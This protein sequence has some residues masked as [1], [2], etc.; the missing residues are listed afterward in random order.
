VDSFP[1]PCPS[2]QVS[3]IAGQLHPGI[4]EIG[5]P[6]LQ[7]A[8]GRAHRFA[9]GSRFKSFTGLTPKASKT[10]ESE[11]KGQAMSKAGPS[12]LRTQLLRSADVARTIDP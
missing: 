11:R 8:V 7:A 4:A 12:L 3:T 9:N 10:G 6:V 5:G 1:G 2:L